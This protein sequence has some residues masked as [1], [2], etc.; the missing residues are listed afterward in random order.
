MTDSPGWGNLIKNQKKSKKNL[1]PILSRDGC[2]GWVL[3][4]QKSLL[5]FLQVEVGLGHFLG[6]PILRTLT[7]TPAHNITR[8]Y[9]EKAT[10]KK[11]ALTTTE[12]PPALY[13]PRTPS[14]PLCVLPL[15]LL[16]LPSRPS[17]LALSSLAGYLQGRRRQQH[18]IPRQ[19]QHSKGQK[20]LTFFLTG[21]FGWG[22]E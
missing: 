1:L 2:V 22:G 5:W 3:F 14:L 8:H 19:L 7:P 21:R 10:R 12:A 11:P 17:S 13:P 16:I 6:G 9:G 20:R 18:D 4:S 15:H